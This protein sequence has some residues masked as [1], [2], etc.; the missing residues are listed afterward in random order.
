[1]LRDGDGPRGR[2]RGQGQR[3]RIAEATKPGSEI[4]KSE[5]ARERR[6]GMIDRRMGREGR[7]KK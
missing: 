2:D 3:Q 5:R 7:E 1:L 4:R 6:G